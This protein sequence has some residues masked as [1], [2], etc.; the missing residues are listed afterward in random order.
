MNPEA[1]MN[2]V[3]TFQ[4]TGTCPR[5]R[6]QPKSAAVG[7]VIAAKPLPPTER[8]AIPDCQL[9]LRGRSGKEA[10]VSIVENYCAPFPTWDEAIKAS[11]SS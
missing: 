1:W 3:V 9:T 4:P 8:G 7:V 10:V 2:K 5:G 11:K 6:A